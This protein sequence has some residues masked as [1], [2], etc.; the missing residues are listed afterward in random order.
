MFAE[1]DERVAPK[2]AEQKH[3]ERRNVGIRRV[4][5]AALLGI[6]CYAN[7]KIPNLSMKDAVER[8]A[9]WIDCVCKRTGYK[10]IDI[11]GQGL[12][13]GILIWKP[14]GFRHRRTEVCVIPEITVGGRHPP[15]Q[16]D[17]D[18]NRYDSARC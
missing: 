6:L 2:H 9:R 8:H 17:C 3:A 18:Y 14:A 13:A 15:Q 11:D 16:G 4:H 5:V 1:Q 12:E 10:A 7:E